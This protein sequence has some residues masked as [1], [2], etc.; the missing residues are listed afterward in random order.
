MTENLLEGYHPAPNRHDELLGGEGA[1]RPHWSRFMAELA[2]SSP[3]QIHERM[4]LVE[5][6]IRDHGITYNVYADPKG[7]DRP[8]EVDPIPL[9]LPAHDWERIEA[10]LAQRARLLNAILA[11]VYG[12]QQL[13]REGYLPPSVVFGNRS[14][15]H[16]AQDI[17][18]PGGIHLFHY[19][20]DLARSPDGQWWVFSDRTQAPSGAGYA[21]ENRLMISRMFPEA[22]HQLG[23]QHQA[24]FFSSWRESLAHHAPRGD[25]PQ[26]LALLTPGPYN[27][28]YFEHALLARYL[29]FVLVEGS[30]L[31]VRDGRVWL[32]T[33]EGLKRVHGIVRRQDDDYCD[34]LEMRSDSALGVPGLTEC[35]RRGTV[36]LANGLG[37]G[38]TESPALLAF[39]PGLC[40]RVL[41]EPLLLPSVATWW[42][43]EPAAL[44][45]A[46]QRLD[47]LIIK[48]V[49]RLSR[50]PVIFGHRLD[51]AGRDALRERILRE[52][53][54]FVAQEWVRLSQAPVL[55]RHRPKQ[56]GA[57]AVGL[58]A[59][60]VA[61]PD[62]YAAM[63]GG[64]TRMGAA[65][66]AEVITMQR[67]GGSKDTWV[68]SSSPVNSAFSLLRT[69]VTA[70]DLASS[71]GYLS[72]RAAENL[73]WF[74]RYAE[75]SDCAA[76]LLRVA[77]ARCVAET[78]E[79]DEGVG[80]ALMLAHAWGMLPED[81][82]DPAQALLQ[83]ATDPA[84]GLGCVLG[85]LARAGFSLRDRLSLDNWR[86]LSQL[87]HDPVFSEP[88]SLPV[89]L[90]WLDRAVITL[91]TLS[92]F[93]L[94]GMTRGTDWRFLSI[95]RR[96]E[97]LSFLCQALLT[98]VD[99][100][101]DSGLDWLLE[102][103]D[104]SVTYRSRYLIAPEWL[105]VLD[106]L[107][108]D[109]ANTRSIAF[110]VRGLGDFVR[111][112][113]LLHGPF[114]THV[115]ARHA[116]VLAR[117]EPAD[118]RPDSERLRGL[119]QALQQAACGLSDEIT[120]KFFA[121]ARLRSMLHL[122]A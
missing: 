22:F 105:P 7:A 104:S 92:G 5:R 2:A 61:T 24:A 50:E 31:T 23:V 30:D 47:D 10:G 103:C 8:W 54:K 78:D 117:L 52:P 112:L 74:G 100:G 77:L 95:G 17:H 94:D 1:M 101:P 106:L 39:L 35:A 89:A 12:P 64:L 44:D 79:Q 26:L 55:D 57:R 116:E 58:R 16:P 3:A 93:A 72:S 122:V 4:A 88:A 120:Q 40:E 107:V 85:Q 38:V 66:E 43:G 11:D 87:A 63:P 48:P 20:A 110:Q 115:L 62:G 21:L 18:P 119:L 96:L 75:R 84:W 71:R 82:D 102:L 41:G 60:A 9:I 33:V 32:K 34:P 15:L 14:Y 99:E 70:E 97:R 81:T 114:G 65:S 6:E 53:H 45:E 68:L 13:M 121:H 49:D 36:L 108:R 42:L 118:L 109:E 76:R 27:E 25:G 73:F 67:G 56:L 91:M 90:N 111:R 28:T 46:W 83:A 98:A 19:A 29:G 51:A 80:G 69:T 37:S 86:T 113:E 59:F